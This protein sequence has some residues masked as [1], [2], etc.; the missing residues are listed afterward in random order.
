MILKYYV[1]L[2][3]AVP[4]KYRGISTRSV[5]IYFNSYLKRKYI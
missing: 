4:T 3:N 5:C 1:V 2:V